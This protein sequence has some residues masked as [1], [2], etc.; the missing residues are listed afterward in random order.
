MAIAAILVGGLLVWIVFFSSDA[1]SAPTI[2]DA[3][4][5]VSASPAAD[6]T[7]L[8][9]SAADTPALEGNSDGTWTVDTGIGDVSR[10]TS[11]YVGFRV[12]EVLDRIGQSEAIGRTPAVGGVLELAG[13]TLESATVEADLRQLRSDRSRRD[14]AIHRALQTR[15]FPD[16]RFESSGPIELDVIPANGETIEVTVPGRL[17]VRGVSRDVE[18]DM[19]VR[20]VNDVVVVGSLPVDFTSFGVAMPRAP[21]VVSVSNEGDLEWQ[22]F[23]RRDR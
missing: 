20:R 9:G 13:S 10:G 3:A 16:A 17:T 11:S 18:A 22:L 6:A 4:A 1:P 19:S 23:F 5:V 7:V 15:D 21:I 12:A 14:P 8:A 2:D